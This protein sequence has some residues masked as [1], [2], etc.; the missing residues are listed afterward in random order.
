[1]TE[2]ETA[3]ELRKVSRT[4]GESAAAVSALEE[5]TVDFR[6]GTFTAVMGPSGSGKTTL[7]QCLAGLVRP[8]SGRVA[9]G[10]VRID[11]LPEKRLARVRRSRVGFVFQEFNLIPALTALENMLLPMR[12][13]GRTPDREWVAEISGRTGIGHRLSHLPHELSGGQQQRVA[14]C[15]ALVTR[16]AVICADEPTGALD[17]SSGREV[18][19]LLR[20]AV[21]VYRQTLVMVTH[22]PVAASYA[23]TVLFLVDGRIVDTMDRP[24]PH[25][26]AEQMTA[27]MERA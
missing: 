1:M 13:A 17:S 24:A 3:A 23:D 4:Y 6:E 16:P 8:S 12:L 21:D 15:R 7:L 20:E 26:V 9:L 14:I 11:G 18:M 22:D 19:A 25:T 27:L 10:G 2:S 5:V